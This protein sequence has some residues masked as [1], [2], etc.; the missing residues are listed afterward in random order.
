MSQ[1]P[2]YNDKPGV[3]VT[4]SGA[5][6]TSVLRPLTY[7]RK[8][9]DANS[10]NTPPASLFTALPCIRGKT[11]PYDRYT[12]FCQEW[13][14]SGAMVFYAEA[15]RQDNTA[16]RQRFALKVAF[17]ITAGSGS[18]G[19][20]FLDT[21]HREAIFYNEHLSKLQGIAV[22]KHYGVWVGR[23]PWGTTV[24]CAIMEWGGRPFDY[25]IVDSKLGKPQRGVKIMESVKAIHDAGLRHNDLIDMPFH[26][27]L[28]DKV[29]EKAFIIDF[30]TAESH[31][32]CLRMRIRPYTSTPPEDVFGCDELWYVAGNMK[33][34]GDG[35]CY[36]PGADPLVVQ[37]MEYVR[38]KRHEARVRREVAEMSAARRVKQSTA[39]DAQKDA[40]HLTL[41]AT[42]VH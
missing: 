36:G 34:F 1:L 41:V 27:I 9:I 14:S 23:T 16:S 42:P 18:P 32:C 2:L 25:T 22:P 20:A 3:K 11:I 28:Y 38:R 30:S 17:N 5:S 37:A 19:G 12:T 6:A 33:L 13:S 21:F 29:R 4:F 40:S 15:A 31:K 39:C 24:A 7:A 8:G 35:P 10:F 26:H